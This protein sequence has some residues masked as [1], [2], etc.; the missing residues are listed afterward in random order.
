MEQQQETEQVRSS[1]KNVFQHINKNIGN[2]ELDITEETEALQII[3]V[4]DISSSLS[5]TSN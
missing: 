1:S 5:E 2:C 4:N 3:T